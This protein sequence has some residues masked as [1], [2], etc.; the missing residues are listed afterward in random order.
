MKKVFFATSAVI[1]VLAS[2]GA[3][4]FDGFGYYA[5]YDYPDPRLTRPC[6]PGPG[7]RADGYPDARYFKPLYAPGGYSLYGYPYRPFYRPIME[8]P[9]YYSLYSSPVPLLNRPCFPGPGC[10]SDGYPNAGY[11]RRM[12]GDYGFYGPSYSYG[13]YRPY[14]PGY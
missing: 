5:P 4:S 9:G 2:D 14:W 6:F 1:M 7:C 10:R 3:L 8:G 11:F 13:G 12:L